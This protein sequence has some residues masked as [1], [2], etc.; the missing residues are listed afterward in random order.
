MPQPQLSADSLLTQTLI[1]FTGQQ[2]QQQ[3]QDIIIIIISVDTVSMS[4]SAAAWK[5]DDK[6][7]KDCPV[8]VWLQ[9]AL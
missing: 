2:Q 4:M 1:T 7:G 8:L 9:L 3:Q 5:K 6:D